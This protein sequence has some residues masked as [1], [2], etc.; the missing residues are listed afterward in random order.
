MV[1][2]FTSNIL[3]VDKDG[4]MDILEMYKRYELC[5]I[6]VDMKKHERHF[7]SLK[8]TS[9][10]RTVVNMIVEEIAQMETRMIVLRREDF[11]SLGFDDDM[12]EK[13]YMQNLV[14]RMRQITKTDFIV[15]NLVI[16]IQLMRIKPLLYVNSFD[17]AHCK[18][19]SSILT[20]KVVDECF[21][22]FLGVKCE[23]CEELTKIFDD[24]CSLAI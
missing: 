24:F 3:A 1:P 6:M 2:D 4:E 13:W 22:A 18:K 5:Y 8:C 20:F 12:Y 21:D 17:C 11:R 10:Q 7:S 16:N 9:R 15:K 14:H 23:H 19:Q